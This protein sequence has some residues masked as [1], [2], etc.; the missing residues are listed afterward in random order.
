M[1]AN[2]FGNRFYSNRKP[3]WHNLG[4]IA[5]EAL[6]ANDAFKAMGP[7]DVHMEAVKLAD[8]TDTG[9]RAIVRDEVPD[10]PTKV[11]FGMVKGDYVLI[12]PQQFVDIWSER[13]PNVKL[14]TM[15]SLGEGRRLFASAGLPQMDILG[16]EV[17]NYLLADIPFTG[18]DAIEIRQTPV[19]VVCQ[20]TLIASKAASTEMYRI[21]HDGK[22]EARLG[23]WM[24]GLYERALVRA[25]FLATNFE[26]FAKAH[27]ATT[28]VTKVLAKIYPDP[29]Y[30]K[31]NAPDSVLAQRESDRAHQIETVQTYR[32][33]V[34]E[35]FNGAATGYAHSAFRGTA[36]GLYNSVAELENYRRGSTEKANAANTL[37]GARAGAIERAYDVLFDLVMVK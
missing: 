19:R 4:F 29:K 15:G 6:S 17:N 7:Y 35:L 27:L 32:D 9:F 20:N 2:I 21:I 33:A 16:D 28:E 34:Q 31:Q 37:F 22:A 13:L 24:E 36:W 11:V 12:T 30:V 25:G 14:E 23:D 8:G 1:S 5:P 3:A 26:L 18:G 10:D